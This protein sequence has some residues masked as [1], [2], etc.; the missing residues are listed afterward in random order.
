MWSR[1]W[2]IIH[3][4]ET[5]TLAPKREQ[6]EKDPGD[7]DTGGCI[8]RWAQDNQGGTEAGEL[9]QFSSTA[10]QAWGG[11]RCNRSTCNLA[12]QKTV[13]SFREIVSKFDTRKFYFTDGLVA[14]LSVTVL[15]RVHFS[16]MFNGGFQEKVFSSCPRSYYSRYYINI[17]RRI[18]TEF[19]C[20]IHCHKCYFRG[21]VQNISCANITSKHVWKH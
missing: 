2:W 11:P 19:C 13:V 1:W 5:R 12:T 15:A 9:L 21:G 10:Q 4:D 18:L 17:K 14:Y 3:W 6:Q 16:T 8:P 7:C 20:N